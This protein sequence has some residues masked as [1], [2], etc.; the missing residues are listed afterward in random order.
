[1]IKHNE[2]FEGKVQ[3]LGMDTEEGYATVGIMEP[4]SYTFSTSSEERMTV[5]EGSMKVKLPGA[6]WQVFGP[7]ETFTVP[8]NASFDIEAAADVA[9]I[10]FYK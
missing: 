7:D 9:Y 5:V 2:Y 6:D 4:G 10:C 8:G 3:S 1:M